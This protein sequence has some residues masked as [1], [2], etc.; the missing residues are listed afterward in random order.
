MNGNTLTWN[1]AS[2]GA[3]QERHFAIHTMVPPDI[4]LLGTQLTSTTALSTAN[5]DG[6]LTNNSGTN[7]RTISGA[8]DPNDKLAYTS[9]G[10]TEVW[11]IGADEWI[12]YTIR[13]QNTGTDTAFNVMV[14]DTLPSDL[15]PG[16][17]SMGAGSHAFTW[18]L[19]DAGTL[20]FRFLNILLPDSNV[21]E[22]ASHGFASF[23]IKPRQPVLTGSTIENVANIFFD[24]NPPV[25]TDP[26]V[27]TAEFSTGISG[28][29]LPEGLLLSPVPVRDVLHFTSTRELTGVK[30]IAADGRLVWQ[31]PVQGKSGDLHTSGLKAG[32]YVLIGSLG[33]GST[34]RQ[35]F[36]KE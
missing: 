1:L 16:S 26:S 4:N 14:T 15:D 35:R 8:Y 12:D 29:S 9:S 3:W 19:R 24:F 7:L 31:Q 27:L 36:V 10:D 6:D 18:E 25:I 33:D 2:L 30:V 13:F 17:I 34:T 20:K 28:R 11:Q 32:M 21:N 23:R 5:T 22:A